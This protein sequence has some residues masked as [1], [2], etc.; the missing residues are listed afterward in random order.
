MYLSMF[1]YMRNQW[2]DP[3]S[4]NSPAR[5]FGGAL[6]PA[7]QKD[8]NNDLVYIY[9]TPYTERG[10]RVASAE[11]LQLQ[12]IERGNDMRAD[13]EDWGYVGVPIFVD[14][15]E[16]DSGNE[17]PIYS[18]LKRWRLNAHFIASPD[19]AAALRTRLGEEFDVLSA[20]GEDGA[21]LQEITM[22]GYASAWLLDY[23]IAHFSRGDPSYE[24]SARS[25]LSGQEAK[26]SDP[27]ATLP[28]TFS[29][30]ARARLH[31]NL[32]AMEE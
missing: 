4:I 12:L 27:Q 13:G 30:E 21:L 9:N 10:E 5:Y 32:A 31:L 20:S 24:C 17:T 19:K 7:P 26:A 23:R 1:E 22:A 25:W 11:A 14:A 3:R 16:W 2:N 29:D 28:Y 15:T 18:L 6:V 8:D